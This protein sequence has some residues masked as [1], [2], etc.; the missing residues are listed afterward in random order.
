MSLFGGNATE[1][2][3]GSP[4]ALAACGTGPRR[5]VS[6]RIAVP[7]AGGHVFLVSL[8]EAREHAHT[9]AH[10]AP[11]R[12]ASSAHRSSAA[13]PEAAILT[14]SCETLRLGLTRT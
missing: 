9:E 10:P 14:A 4:R 2:D 6:G 13:D 5:R 3:F 11:H 7:L 12:D 1:L 8:L